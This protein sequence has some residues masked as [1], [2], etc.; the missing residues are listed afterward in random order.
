MM[1]YLLDSYLRRR[2]WEWEEQAVHMV[3]A[4][5][6]ALDENPKKRESSDPLRALSR[7]GVK[8]PDV[9]R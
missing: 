6:T 3:N 8:V 9:Q 1:D 7:L 4:L 5:G 2:R